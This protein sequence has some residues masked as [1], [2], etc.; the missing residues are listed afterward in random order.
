[1]A[2][3]GRD[4]ARKPMPDDTSFSN[5]RVAIVDDNRNFQNMLRTMLRTFGFRRIDVIGEADKVMTHLEQNVVDLVFLDLVMVATGGSRESGLDLIDE[6]RHAGNLANRQMPIVLVTGHASRGVVE[7]AMTT[8]A[9]HVLAKPVSPQA[10]HGAVKSLL[11]TM[12]TYV[13]GRDGYFGPDIEAARRRLRRATVVAPLRKQI[14][15][16]VAPAPAV[17][18]AVPGMNVPVREEDDMTFLD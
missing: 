11:G 8:G 12:P 14:V 13:K 17:R 18:I 9:D 5:S 6:I 7:R 4:E 15:V 3:V 10:V 16:P 2:Q 1:V